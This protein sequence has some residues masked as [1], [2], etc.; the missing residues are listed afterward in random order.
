[1]LNIAFPILHGASGYPTGY[2]HSNWTP[3]PT[4]AVGIL[5]LIA[6]YIAWTGPLNRRRPDEA[7]RPV[8]AAQKTYF[9]AGALAFLIALGPPLDDWADH[10][11]LS[12][13]MF[14]HLILIF[15]VAPLWLAG[16]PAWFFT[17]ILKRP[18]LSKIGFHL[19]RPVVAFAI[20]NL[21]ITIWHLPGPYDAALR[22]EQLHVVQHISILGAALLAWWTILS[23]LPAWPRL[24]PPLQCLYL[25]F[26]TLPGGAIGAFI[27]LAGPGIY[28]FY[29]N[30]PR[31]WGLN[32][33]TD[34]EIAGLMMW[35]G[36]SLIY[37][38]WITALFFR[39]AAREEEKETPARRPSTAGG[40]V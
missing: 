3:E 12:A 7:L 16:I 31:L 29:D 13:H 18:L 24:S 20:S 40:R 6:A 37:L 39:W 30:V 25:F 17:P 14:Q 34:Q 33:E 21:I 38:L 23:P 36:S 27:T 9:V 8:T 5:A 35:V 4:V 32:L 28:S 2:L 11:L 26:E 10:Y 15:I 19:T 1:M 22:N